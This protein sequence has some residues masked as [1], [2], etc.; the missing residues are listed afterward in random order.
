MAKASAGLPVM[1]GTKKAR[2]S[3]DD[4]CAKVFC[5][6]WPPPP[7]YENIVYSSEGYYDIV[8]RYCEFLKW[9]G[10]LGE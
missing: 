9:C 10:S 3:A 8:F 1:I 6:T 7:P 2:L 4:I 5:R